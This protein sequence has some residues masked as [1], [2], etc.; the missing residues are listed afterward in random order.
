[1][2]G[3]L[4]CF[5]TRLDGVSYSTAS[6]SLGVISASS[7]LILRERELWPSRGLE[8]PS[9]RMPSLRGV[10]SGSGLMTDSAI[11][12]CLRLP[13]DTALFGVVGLR[14][15]TGTEDA[16]VWVFSLSLPLIWRRLT[17]LSF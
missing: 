7:A 15:V 16:L 3:R 13:V 5:R 1:M 14:G 10:T 17:K 4:I 6:R 9:K 12:T 8:S 11:E 2:F